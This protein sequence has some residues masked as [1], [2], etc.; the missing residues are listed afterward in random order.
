MAGLNC[1]YQLKKAGY[2]SAVYEGSKRIGG[3][4]FSESNLL[5]TDLYTELGG[6]FIDSD[7]TDMLQ[8]CSE[9]RLSLLNTRTEAETKYARDSFYIDGRFYSQNE[10][11]RAFLPYASRINAD[12]GSLPEE[13]TY[14]N[15]N[16]A[17]KHFDGMSVK[18]Y[19]VLS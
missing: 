1:A 4:I 15:Y 5:A 2:T 3:R 11:I 6:E 16:Q 10:V 17:S 9:F 14:D 18:G 7:H 19:L 13:I 8:L 12:I